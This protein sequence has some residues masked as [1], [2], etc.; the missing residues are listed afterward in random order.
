M[1]GI[2]KNKSAAIKA[3]EEI[4]M[5]QRYDPGK[6][7]KRHEIKL[8]LSTK[9]CCL[10]KLKTQK[11]SESTDTFD[12]E[13]ASTDDPTVNKVVELNKKLRCEMRTEI[14]GVKCK[15]FTLAETRCVPEVT[16]PELHSAELE[17]KSVIEPKTVPIKQHDCG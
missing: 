11:T 8:P 12:W 9:G 17:S 4:S 3:S 6:L 15:Q 2:T 14:P 7:G 1:G 5:I 10:E 13:Y 16:A